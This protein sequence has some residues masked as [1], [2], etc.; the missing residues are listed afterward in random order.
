MG[1]N[2]SGKPSDCCSARLPC[3]TQH[4][5]WRT[6]NEAAAAAG[7][8]KADALAL[9]GQQGALQKRRH[10]GVQRGGLVRG[11]QR[12]HHT[13]AK[14]AHQADHAPCLSQA[15]RAMAACTLNCTVHPHHR[16]LQ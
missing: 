16:M 7:Q 5:N 10:F 13:P 8:A 11:W 3:C 4:P 12:A 15:V 6:R 1:R 2:R 9:E 14:T